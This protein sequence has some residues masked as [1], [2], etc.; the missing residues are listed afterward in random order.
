[1][2]GNPINALYINVFS[3][4]H[5]SILL[6][7][8]QF[9]VLDHA[10]RSNVNVFSHSVLFSGACI[11]DV[12]SFKC[13]CSAGFFGKTCHNGTDECSP[14]PCA[15]AANCTDLHLDYNVSMLEVLP[16][17][18]NL[19]RYVKNKTICSAM[20]PRRGSFNKIKNKNKR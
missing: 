15:N 4:F 11:D 7:K 19:F 5:C 20:H 1:M 17:L 2:K 3:Y 16:L 10:L 18:L 9:A 12:N 14:N 6:G 13:N 8:I